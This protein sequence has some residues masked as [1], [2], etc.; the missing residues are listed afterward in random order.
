MS[1]FGLKLNIRHFVG[2]PK[3]K[4]D[5]LFNMAT[6]SIAYFDGKYL[7]EIIALGLDINR[8]APKYED[9]VIDIGSITLLKLAVVSCQEEI[10]NI[11]LCNGAKIELYLQSIKKIESFMLFSGIEAS[12]VYERRNMLNKKQRTISEIKRTAK[13]LIG[14][15]KHRKI[16]P[17]PVASLLIDRFIFREI[18]ISIWSSRDTI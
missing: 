3:C 17:S 14:I 4:A 10:I 8:V 1:C 12:V 9:M 15:R 7:K 6:Y 2:C 18:A 13:I 5:A 16:Y 11:L